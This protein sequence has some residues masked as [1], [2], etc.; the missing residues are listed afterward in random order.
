[1]PPEPPAPPPPGESEWKFE[2]HGIVGVSIYA[3]DTPDFVLNGQG[4]LLALAQPSGPTI[5][6]GGDVRQSRINFSM[7][8]PEAF[9]AKPKAVVEMD[10]FGLNSPGGYGEVS[11]Y[12]RLRLAYAELKWE[13]DVLRF[14]QDH[15]L[16]L[17]MIPEGMG[18]MAFPVTYFNGMLGWREP[19]VGYY[20]TESFGESKL[21]L[22]LQLIKSDWQNP[23]DFGLS[24]VNDLNVDYGQLSGFLG[25]EARVKFT[26]ENLM[27]YVAGHYNHVA[28]SRAGDLVAPPMAIPNRDWDVYAGVVG[29]KVMA[30]GFTAAASAYYGDNL[31][32]LLG[33]LLQFP[34]TN[35]VHEWGAWGE[36]GYDFTKV[37]GAWV[38]GGTAQP[39]ASDVEAAGG[40]RANSSVIGGM[41][42]IKEHGFAMGPEFY[43]VI[44]KNI[45]KNGNGV[46]SGTGAQKGDIG[47]D[48]LMLT[49]MYF[50]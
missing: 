6:M 44:A 49:G 36:L 28:G 38:V 24:T 32:P 25:A 14:G 9:G 43:H 37:V 23:T 19:G 8:G 2:F 4:P 39:N 48:Q 1:M 13:K 40:G 21:E 26:S 10:M 34:V 35:D 46:P 5:T 50:F 18:H 7:Q 47:V 29:V 31:G 42:R 27:A 16:I 12:S 30:G 20:H 45:D 3:Q 17:G 22:A 11:V 15:E 33:N 41:I